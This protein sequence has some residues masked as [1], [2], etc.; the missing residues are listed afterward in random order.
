MPISLG[1]KI[2]SL[3]LSGA[4]KTF[5]LLHRLRSVLSCP[6]RSCNRNLGQKSHALLYFMHLLIIYLQRSAIL[7][8]TLAIH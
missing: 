2:H 8:R 4:H 1:S 7:G 3:L 6:V 5:K